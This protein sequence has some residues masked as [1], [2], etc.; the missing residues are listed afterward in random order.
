MN[1]IGSLANKN[2]LFLQ[3]PMGTFFK[4]LDNAFRQK[5]ASTYKIGF[6]MGDQFFSNKDNYTPFRGTPEIWPSFIEEFLLSKKIDKI[7]L[8]GDCR[9]YQRIARSIAYEHKIDVYVFEEGYLRPYYITLEKFGVN[10][11]SHLSRDPQTY[12]A[13]SLENLPKPLHA[14]ASKTKM[15]ASA[16]LYYALSNIFKK[17][18]PHYIHHREFSAVKEFFYGVRGAVRKL[19]YYF[20]EKHYLPE[21]TQTLSKQ[22][23]FVPLQTHNDFQVL[24]HSTYRSIEKFI[25][26][27]LESFAHHAPQDVYLV[28]K[29][30]PVD[31]G[32]KNYKTFIYE[33]ASLLD[34]EKRVLTIHDVHLPSCLKHAIGT[35]TINSTVGLTSIGYGI[36]TLTLGDAIYDIKGL[37]NKGI[38][39]KKFWHQHK[40]PD[41]LLY[42]KFKQYLIKTTQLNGSFYGRMPDELK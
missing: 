42:Q 37:T 16:T 34:I 19:I 24:Q 36:P 10:G 13:L 29:H 33:Q 9:Y 7:F 21:I 5:D 40:K 1:S 39:L 26:E 2:I 20:T 27:I 41:A 6:N 35:I 38:A 30:H 3:G 23:Y 28:F 14:H 32:R 25:I 11:F 31:R 4:K 22:Y 17:K 8:F 18:Y 15:I 12:N